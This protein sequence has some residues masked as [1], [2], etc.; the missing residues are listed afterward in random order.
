[1]TAAKNSANLRSG[2]DRLGLRIRSPGKQKRR[3]RPF[4]ADAAVQ[5]LRP[6]HAPQSSKP[7]SLEGE[8]GPQGR[9]RVLRHPQRFP[10]RTRKHASELARKPGAAF[11]NSRNHATGHKRF[12]TPLFF[13][14]LFPSI[15]SGQTG[16]QRLGVLAA[17]ELKV[18]RI[19]P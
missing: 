13:C 6:F 11:G 4:G 15:L 3:R 9:V 12:L 19:A 8:V 14:F 2:Q 10:G 5:R 1:M 16:S 17:C 7:L 18:V